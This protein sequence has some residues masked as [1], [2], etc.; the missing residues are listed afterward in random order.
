MYSLSQSVVWIRFPLYALA[1]QTWLARDRD[2][3]I[4][5]LVSILIGMITMCLILIAETL[6]EPKLRLSWPYGDLVPGGYLVKVSLPLFCI[7]MAISTKN[8][9]K[10]NIISGVIG[11]FTIGIS[12]LTVNGDMF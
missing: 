1:A 12:V 2:I 10:T 5:M 7:L 11:L 4:M 8:F 3:R 6:I 9:G